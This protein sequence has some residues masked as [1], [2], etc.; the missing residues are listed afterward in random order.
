MLAAVTATTAT[1][2]PSAE[3]TY[4]LAEIVGCHNLKM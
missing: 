4:I 1:T 2:T 3:A